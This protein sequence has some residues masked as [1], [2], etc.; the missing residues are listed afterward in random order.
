MKPMRALLLS[1]TLFVLVTSI[2]L[3]FGVQAIPEPL[4]VDGMHGKAMLLSS[5]RF[6]ETP[7]PKVKDAAPVIAAVSQAN[8]PDYAGVAEGGAVE[9][10][11]QPAQL[12]QPV[13]LAQPAIAGQ[14]VQL[15]GR[16][17]QPLDGVLTTF[18]Q[19]VSNGQ[20]GQVVG[21]YVPNI[22]ELQV[23]QQPP[24]N[25]LFV[26]PQIGVATQF[27]QAALNGV[28]GLL[29][30]NTSS[31][32]LYYQINLGEQVEVVYGDGKVERYQVRSISE[33]QKLQTFNPM[34]DFIDLDTGS[35]LTSTQVFNR[36]YSGDHRLTL[37]TCLERNGDPNWGLH[38]IEAYPIP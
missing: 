31:G 13:Q 14:D 38:F 29:A 37:Q 35:K 9:Q 12:A 28:I 8:Q 36:F 22:L 16:S 34:S 2:V 20:M 33:F 25:S 17:L 15:A 6:A 11:A 10:L 4:P 18:T 30:H 1:S 24:S 26:S 23:E 7:F 3:I 27:G 32:I 19:Q 21:V 5:G